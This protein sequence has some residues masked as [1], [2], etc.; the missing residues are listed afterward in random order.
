MISV[1]LTNKKEI[2]QLMSRL[3]R[4]YESKVVRKFL[5]YAV[6]PLVERAKQLAPI[7]P[8][9]H[10]GKYGLVAPGTLKKSIGTIDMKRSRKVAL[11]VGLRV[12]GA[13]SKNRS[14]FYGQWIERGTKNIPAHPF[15][16]PAYD[17][18]KEEI[19]RR[20]EQDAKKVFEKEIAKWVKKGKI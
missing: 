9:A 15:M 10:R 4:V 8:K 17:M 5:K 11:V 19:I 18:T 16:R 3:P 6:A 7:A 12:K 13:F 1:E 2:L 14:G 20:F